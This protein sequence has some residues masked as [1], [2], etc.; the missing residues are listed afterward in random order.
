MG[1]GAEVLKNLLK[2]PFTKRYP[3]EKVKPQERYRGKLTVKWK[4]CIACGL[5]RMICPA[6]AITLGMKV[7]EIKSG[8][9]TYKKILHPI[10]SINMGRCVS[11]GLCV[12]ICPVKIISFTNK[13]EMTSKLRKDLLVK[14]P[15]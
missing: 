4:D 3:K 2:K 12:D 5:C 8:K 10:K 6:D 11:C 13:F 14:G 9:I 1:I 7:E 15:R